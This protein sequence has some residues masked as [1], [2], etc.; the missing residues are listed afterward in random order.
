M[1]DRKTLSHVRC[2]CKYV[3]NTVGFVK[4]KFDNSLK[5]K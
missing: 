3:S 1:K 5:I 2:A 4:S